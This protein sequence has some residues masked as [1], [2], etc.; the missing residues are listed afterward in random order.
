M[1]TDIIFGN[2]NAENK[3]MEFDFS[4]E[5]IQLGGKGRFVTGNLAS[6]V[7]ELLLSKIR[8]LAPG[9]RLPSEKA[10]AKHFGVSRTVIRQTI[11]LLKADGLVET[12]KGSGTFI[13][14]H[15]LTHSGASNLLTER[16]IQALLNLIEVRR[17]IEAEMAR[18]AA[19]RRSPGQ[20]A[21][22]EQSLRRLAEATAAGSDGV[23]ED[24]RFHRSIA[25]ATGNP[26]WV[27]FC[28]MFAQQIQT[29]VTATRAN[30]RRENIVHQ[31]MCE[32]RKIL[33]AIA[34]GNAAAAQEAAA[35]H[36]EHAAERVRAADLKFWQ[37][38]SGLLIR[39][40]EDGFDG[41]NT[42]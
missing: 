4:P 15:E 35:E 2:V 1:R 26:F 10:M 18:V 3:L 20:L 14:D 40:I 32:H 30:D 31:V 25:A 29:A 17:S 22:I 42:E 11:A 33:D 16:S 8:D 9:T 24:A 39:G 21:E 28:D 27:R 36:M 6:R 37:G 12:R 5:S 41:A 38:K 7:A 13:L 23:D 19:I 34:E